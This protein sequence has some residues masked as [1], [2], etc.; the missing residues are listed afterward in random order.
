MN[1]RLRSLGTA[2]PDVVYKTGLPTFWSGGGSMQSV[3]NVD[4]SI[5]LFQLVEGRPSGGGGSPAALNELYSLTLPAGGFFP[6][7]PSGIG[8]YTLVARFAS[9][10]TGAVINADPLRGVAVLGSSFYF[11]GSAEA[12]YRGLSGGSA[13]WQ[14]ITTPSVSLKPVMSFANYQ[15]TGVTRAEG[16]GS[17]FAALESFSGGAGN[18]LDD[19]LVEVDPRINH[20]VN[21]F[22]VESYAATGDTALGGG[23]A[24]AWLNEQSTLLSMTHDGTNVIAAFR[25]AGPDNV[26]NN[27][28]DRRFFVT[29]NPFATNATG[30]PI[31]RR[32]DAIESGIDLR[33]IAAFALGGDV[34]S[35]S[36]ATPPEDGAFDAFG[37]DPLFNHMSYSIQAAANADF[38]D[39]VKEYI[40]SNSVG[41]GTCLSHALLGSVPTILANYTNVKDGVGRAIFNLTSGLSPSHPCFQEGVFGGYVVLTKN[42]VTAG[43]LG[44]AFYD[45]GTIFQNFGG[46]ADLELEA[47]LASSLDFNGNETYYYIAGGQLDSSYAPVAATNEL[48]VGTRPLSTGTFS[49]FSSL[50]T[51]SLPSAAQS[52]PGVITGLAVMDNV[53]YGARSKYTNTGGTV[54]SPRIVSISTS[55]SPSA[56]DV[57]DVRMSIK[58]LG[59]SDD[60]GSIFAAGLYDGGPILRPGSGERGSLYTELALWEIDPRNKYVRDTWWGVNGDFNI[61]AG[62]VQGSGFS[63]TAFP[64]VTHIGDVAVID[65]MVR[66]SADVSFSAPGGAFNTFYIT[67]NPDARGASNPFVVSLLSGQ[68]EDVRGLTGDNEGSGFTPPPVALVTPG[69]GGVDSTTINPLFSQ[70]SYSSRALDSGLIRAIYESHFLATANNASACQVS[71]VFTTQL[72]AA[73]TAHAGHTSGIGRVTHDLRSPLAPGDA[74]NAP[75]ISPP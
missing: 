58:G 22:P 1:L 10:G 50:G 72:P 55:G 8:N 69:T 56:T 42:T 62:T 9:G 34:G 24:G 12:F 40:V 17:I 6:N 52:V 13:I 75:A 70:L 5:T 14:G 15:V 51:V 41:G 49:G 65:R 11:G 71:A 59:G 25:S 45:N 32:I 2:D 29:V 37:F 16:R 27:G 30:D 60:R 38:Q 19:L 3:R 21:L 26:L 61:T 47:G 53:L 68:G 73:L 44:D 4:G 39:L 7:Q 46:T 18:L 31:V 66:I 28:D 48:F 67:V 36:I 57:V 20:L 43:D 63:T 33:G 74:C 54:L 23:A 64:N 35:A